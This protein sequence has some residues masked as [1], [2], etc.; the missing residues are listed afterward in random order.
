MLCVWTEKYEQTKNCK[1]DNILLQPY[2][3]GHKSA[4]Y[5]IWIKSNFMHYFIQQLLTIR[6]EK[7]CSFVPN[8]VHLQHF[9]ICS[10]Y[11]LYVDSSSTT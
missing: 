2:Y 7:I 1:S 6:Y 9:I 3:P 11:I 5:I 8:Q 4:K 10:I